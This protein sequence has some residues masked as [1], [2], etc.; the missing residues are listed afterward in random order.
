MGLMSPQEWKTKEKTWRRRLERIFSDCLPSDNSRLCT[1]STL[2]TLVSISMENCWS[3][4]ANH[5]VYLGRV[6]RRSISIDSGLLLPW[7]SRPRPLHQRQII[8]RST[9]IASSTNIHIR[10]VASWIQKLLSPLELGYEPPT[11]NPANNADFRVPGT[12]KY[13]E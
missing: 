13:A 1:L 11:S 5:A 6:S 2:N 9:V 8:V 7:S 10:T 4:S 3:T 12:V